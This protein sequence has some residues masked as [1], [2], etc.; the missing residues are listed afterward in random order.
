MNQKKYFND[1]WLFAKTSLDVTYEQKDLW[2]NLLKPVAI[3]HD[4]LISDTLNLYGDATGFYRKKF[5]YQK[6]Q[7]EVVQLNFDGIY[8]DS[9]LYVNDREIGQWKYGYSPVTYDITQALTEGENDLVVMVVHRSPN[10]RWYSG[11]GIYR[12]IQI[13]LQDL[14]HIIPDGIYVSTKQQGEDFLLHVDTEVSL[15]AAT[16]GMT[17]KYTL[18]EKGK[19]VLNEVQKISDNKELLEQDITPDGRKSE[20]GYRVCRE[21]PVVKPHLWHPQDPYLY[22]LRVELVSENE[23]RIFEC[24]NLRVGF[25]TK[26]FTPKDGFL[27]NGEKYRIN[28]VCEHHDFGALGAAFSKEAMRRKFQ[29]LKEMGVNGLRTSH[30]MPAREVL[31]L[32]D[33]MGFLVVAEAFDMW[34]FPKTKYDYAR[35][36]KDW[37]D[38]DIRSYVRRDRSHVCLTMWSVGNEIYDT[39]ANDHGQEIT[40]RLKTAVEKYDYYKNG[41][42]TIGSNYMAWEGAQKCADLTGFAGYNYG[43]TLYNEHHEKYPQWVIYGS[44]TA[45]V[46][47]SRGIYHFPLNK[48]ILTDDDEQCSS[49]G[50][51]C[52]SWG[53]KCEEYCITRDRDTKYSCGQFLWTGFDYIGEPTPYQTK[54]SYFGQI[55]TAGMPKDAFYIYK[56][57]WT[58]YKK[59]PFVHI[60]PNWDFNPGQLVDVRVCSNAPRVSLYVNGELKV[61]KEIDHDHGT[62]LLAQV[63]LPYEKGSIMGIAYDENGIEL[64]R[65]ERFTPSDAVRFVLKPEKQQI[66]ADGEDLVYVEISAVD[67]KGYPVDNDNHY[68]EVLVEGSGYLV[69]LDNGDSTDYDSYEGTIRKLFSGKLMAVIASGGEVGE[70]KITARD[71]RESRMFGHKPVV[72]LENHWTIEKTGKL[73]ESAVAVIQSLPATRTEGICLRKQSE[74]AALNYVPVGFVP[75]RKLEI[76]CDGGFRMC[77]ERKEM[78]VEVKTYPEDATLQPIIFKAVTASGIETNLARVSAN[79]NKALVTAR[80][81]GE[82]YIRAMVKNGTDKV[83]VISQIECSIEGMGAATLNPYEFVVGGLFNRSQGAVLSGIANG[84]STAR[85]I[86]A[87]GYEGLDFGEYGSDEITV[88]V[89]ANSNDA[90]FIQFYEGMPGEEGSELL[91]EGVYHKPSEWQVFKPETYHLKKRLRGVTTLSVLTRDSLEFGGFVFAKKNPALE[92][93]YIVENNNIYGDSFEILSDSVEKIGNNVSIQYEN[94]DFTKEGITRITICGRTP[95]EKNTIHI[96]FKDEENSLNK[97]VEFPKEEEYTEHTFEIGEVKGIQ[98]LSFIFLPGCDFDFKWFR[99]S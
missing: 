28:G 60:F 29:I 51:S 9:V 67:E 27:L 34:E 77:P 55:D 90:Q 54:N 82:F 62:D 16:E 81:D 87:V 95:L 12:N 64:A 91:Y 58:D 22:D 97:I 78:L 6:E 56:G 19:V 47:K 74:F 45:S 38:T 2:Q 46:I 57:E 68:V 23:N 44:E 18:F 5:I 50:N 4:F 79:G 15:D 32:A 41:K 39:H 70:I 21:I 61:E 75:V 10:S 80:G 66:R 8:M 96:R 93:N 33:E 99:F 92:K 59:E 71:V 31:E 84:A 69:G 53:A 48:T 88:S 89:F 13:Y 36:F 83:K 11:A 72:N 65:E 30:N 17:L 14:K 76:S 49:L 63:S 86:S 73:L 3:P 7:G 42:V 52:T 35:F 24:D 43:E 94:L 20:P 25:C 26:E 40:I 37:A 85:G 1:G 98:N